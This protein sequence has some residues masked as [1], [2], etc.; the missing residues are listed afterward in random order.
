[1]KNGNYIIKFVILL[2]VQ[3]VLTKYCRIGY[4]IF[5]SILPAMILCAPTSN[6]T[7]LTGLLA[8]VSG[9]AV[10][11]LSDGVPGLNAAALVPVAF[12]QKPFIRIFIDDEIV[13]RHYS[14]SFWEYGIIKVGLA[15]LAEMAVYFAI[16]VIADSAGTRTVWF[17]LLTFF[18]S[19][20]VSLVFCMVAVNVLAPRQKR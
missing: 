4:H 9:L 15:L 10:D 17:N 6:K 12:L 14:F 11:F 13:E 5:I 1:M 2:L 19:M 20:A 8:F 18:C 16:Y 3:M 7:F